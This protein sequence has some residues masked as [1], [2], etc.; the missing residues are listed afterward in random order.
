MTAEEVA[1]R[2][3]STLDRPAEPQPIDF[4]R[5]DCRDTGSAHHFF[6]AGLFVGAASQAKVNDFIASWYSHPLRLLHE[7]SLSCGA[8][9]RETYRLLILPSRHPPQ[10]VRIEVTEGRG[11]VRVRQLRGASSFKPGELDIEAT[12]NLDSAEVLALRNQVQASNFWNIPQG[13]H[14]RF[15]CEGTQWVLE[16]RRRDGYHVVDRLAPGEGESWQLC[17]LLA[18]IG[19]IRI[20]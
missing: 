15:G 17:T 3:S 11:R 6:P 8:P 18:R 19:G 12:R 7:R 1:R 14:S 4:D 13:E 10:V 2:L 20:R 9:H 5:E 16:G